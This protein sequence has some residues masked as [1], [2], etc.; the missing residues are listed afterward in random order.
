ML[1]NRTQDVTVRLSKLRARLLLPTAAGQ[2][3]TVVDNGVLLKK[4]RETEAAARTAISRIAENSAVFQNVSSIYSPTNINRTR[5]E[6][7]KLELLN[8]T[9]AEKDRGLGNRGQS[10]KNLTAQLDTVESL[11]KANAETVGERVRKIG[12]LSH[13]VRNH[14]F[15]QFVDWTSGSEIA[16]YFGKNVSVSWRERMMLI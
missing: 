2:N 3:S 13:Q 11:W 4:F 12:E 16:E 6:A 5:A 15:D 7:D 9:A 14:T 8:R 1:L 10:G